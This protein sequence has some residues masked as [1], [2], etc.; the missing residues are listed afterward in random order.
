MSQLIQE[1]HIDK[2]KM[3]G[4]SN[5]LITELSNLNAGRGGLVPGN[6]Q[7]PIIKWEFAM[8][9]DINGVSY[10]LQNLRLPISN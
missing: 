2:R 6:L 5:D 7:L 3:K 10:H 9:S 1:D 4:I 8:F